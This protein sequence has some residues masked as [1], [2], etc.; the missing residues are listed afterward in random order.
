MRLWG[1]VMK[2]LKR[3]MIILV[4]LMFTF[5][6][7]MAEDIPLGTQISTFMEANKIIYV[8]EQ[9]VQG[10]LVDNELAICIED[11]KQCGF[12]GIWD[13]K[14]RRSTFEYVGINRKDS[15][16]E[17]VKSNINGNSIVKSDVEVFLDGDKVRTYSTDGYCLVKIMDLEDFS[18]INQG[19][20]I[21]ITINNETLNNP[22]IVKFKD[23]ILQEI[24]RK[25]LKQPYGRISKESLMT[26]ES[27]SETDIKKQFESLKDDEAI[28]K[29]LDGIENLKNLRNL[30]LTSIIK[31]ED[32][33]LIKNMLN[34]KS[35]S[36]HIE[37]EQ[38]YELELL[39]DL[40]SLKKL[41]LY[42][43][44]PNLPSKRFFKELNSLDE[45]E[46][47]L[48]IGY[49]DNDMGDIIVD[50]S[51]L[52]D[53]TTLTKLSIREKNDPYW[54]YGTKVRGIGDLKNLKE[55]KIEAWLFALEDITELRN[56]RNLEKLY[57]SNENIDDFE[58]FKDMTNLKELYVLKNK[59]NISSIK[60]LMNL[61]N[62]KTLKL[63]IGEEINV[64]GP[65]DISLLGNLNKLEELEL[66][67]FKMVDISWIKNLTNLKV[68]DLSHNNIEDVSA[69]ASLKGI[70]EIDLSYNNIQDIDTIAKQE[71]LK[72]L[73]ISYNDELKLPENLYLPNLETLQCV[74]NKIDAIS[75]N[76]K[77]SQ[78]KS[79][80]LS[81]NKLK[82][83]SK[84]ENIP[85]I[86]Q[87][88]LSGNNI[89][90]IDFL[91]DMINL[92]VLYL[93]H[94]SI[95]VILPLKSLAALEYLAL[96]ENQITDIKQISSLKNLINL[97][98]EE[99]M[100]E[101]IVDEI[102]KSTYSNHFKDVETDMRFF[103]KQ[104]DS[105][106]VELEFYDTPNGID[107]CGFELLDESGQNTAVLI[108]PVLG[109]PSGKWR[110]AL[111]YKYPNRSNE[112]GFGL[113]LFTEYSS[114]AMPIKVTII[115]DV[116]SQKADIYVNG[117]LKLEKM[118]FDMKVDNISRCTLYG[119]VRLKE[120]RKTKTEE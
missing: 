8:N 47:I 83:I 60:S 54:A 96:G 7:S 26:I 95:K 52:K 81:R 24:I 115:A 20:T 58:I 87:L 27:I 82:T 21:T 40:K 74:G 38:G 33:K 42:A 53:I 56:L 118:D 62:L 85:N 64:N 114:G 117:E 55:L 97:N 11:L 41:K 112:G 43:K 73:N 10:Y 19:E 98:M 77:M 5:S 103:D 68:V 89:T 25:K 69:M 80:N 111:G 48:S 14:H 18:N 9:R 84:I 1:D 66:P 35:L 78:L 105:I 93:N 120:I 119:N 88:D 67:R 104:T 51:S 76:Q 102:N 3:I 30:E 23:K 100:L 45:F 32:K 63:S 113:Q 4:I 12:E 61:K 86:V 2:A 6:I 65:Y 13:S 106:I 101:S 34:L 109:L 92:K 116:A 16:K 79:L 28:I 49:I 57:I 90:D 31:S 29:S 17:I 39:K 72:R 108:E 75:F 46:L 94:N 36:L 15:C 37:S 71:K 110:S 91:K 59:G 50:L 107:T 44:A 99:I 70:E 22:E